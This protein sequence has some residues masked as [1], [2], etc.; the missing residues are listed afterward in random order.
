MIGP[1]KSAGGTY[2]S[3]SNLAVEDS[4]VAIEDI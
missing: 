2:R 3:R 4:E 1:E